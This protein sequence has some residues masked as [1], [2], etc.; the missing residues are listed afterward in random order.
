VVLPQ[1]ELTGLRLAQTIE[2]LLRDPD[3]LR[4]MGERSR[5][6]GRADAAEAIVQG[7]LALVQ[8]VKR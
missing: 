2:A 5:T 1:A 6:L 8:D 4:V 3:R 7:C